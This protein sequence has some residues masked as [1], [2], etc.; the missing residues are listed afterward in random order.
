MK[1][2]IQLTTPNELHR[3]AEERMCRMSPESCSPQSQEDTERQVHELEVHGIELTIQN[4]EL[5]EARH[6]VKTELDKYTD[7]Y[8]S[9]P[10]G[11]F[12]LDRSG[13]IIA[14]NLA[15]ANLLRIERSLL[16]GSRFEQFV[17]GEDY[18]TFAAFLE[19]VFTSKI[20]ETC[21]IVI[22]NNVG[23]PI[24][25]Q[26]G[27]TLSVAGEECRLA[28]INVTEQ[29]QAEELLRATDAVCLSRV[30]PAKLELELGVCSLR[31]ALDAALVMLREKAL[32]CCLDIKLDLATEVD[33]RIVAD[34]NMLKQI[35]F[36]L[37]ANAIR[38]TAAGG[39]VGVSTVREG[40][41]IKVCVS[42][43]GIGISEKD[44]PN[45]FQPFTVLE[46]V[47]TAGYEGSGLGLA[48]TRQ[49][50]ELHGGTIRVE[51]EVGTGSRFSFTIPLR[52]CQGIT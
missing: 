42:D 45:L 9:A 29:K 28:L 32:D 6:E 15:A 51:S 44:I 19:A 10:V 1:N 20:D 50:V 49:L 30:E 5:R 43:S 52:N 38:F 17:A 39:N 35:L 18:S 14:M 24:R 8:E 31:E 34:F 7:L 37:L 2:M 33:E 23:L 21:E 3:I 4:E 13:S 40:D 36:S 22:L 16:I 48:L 41:L 26:I 46:S 11:Y 47:Y 12:T 27:S 25:V